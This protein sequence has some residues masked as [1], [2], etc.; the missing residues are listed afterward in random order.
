MAP[1]E[2]TE[3]RRLWPG[4]REGGSGKETTSEKLSNLPRPHSYSPKRADAE[5]FRGVP[6]AFKKCRE[7]FRACWGSR[8]LLFLFKAISEAGPAQNS[9][10]ITLE[11]AGGLEDTGSHWLSWARCK[12]LYING[13]TDPWKDAQAW[14][15]IVSCKKGK[16]TPEREGRN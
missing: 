12:V 11:K 9:C 13:F 10:G 5:S 4:P 16:G 8:E 2:S 3:G 15:L 1:T 14:I 6:A 7:V